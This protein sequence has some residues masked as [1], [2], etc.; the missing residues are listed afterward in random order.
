MTIVSFFL[1]YWGIE[2]LLHEACTLTTKDTDPQDRN[3]LKKVSAY[4]SIDSTKCS[5]LVEL[6][7]NRV[8]QRKVCSTL[9]NT[10]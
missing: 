3:R 9:L 8:E 1:L 10:Q 2:F 6:D 5:V 7:S 4:S